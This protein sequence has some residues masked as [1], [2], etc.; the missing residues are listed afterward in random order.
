MTL[1][2][3]WYVGKIQLVLR[4]PTMR[5]A[6]MDLIIYIYRHIIIYIYT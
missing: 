1:A 4:I 5:Y 2:K 3:V 6:Q